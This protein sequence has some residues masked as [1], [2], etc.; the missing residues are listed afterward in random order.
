MI[1][2]HYQLLQYIS[3]LDLYYL[4][5]FC[6]AVIN[7]TISF[8]S[9]YKLEKTPKTQFY[10]VSD[11]LAYRTLVFYQMKKRKL[12]IWHLQFP[13][14]Y[15]RTVYREPLRKKGI[16]FLNEYPEGKEIK[17]NPM[18]C[19]D[20]YLSP[21]KKKGRSTTTYTPFFINHADDAIY[22]NLLVGSFTQKSYLIQYAQLIDIIDFI[23]KTN[24]S[25]YDTVTDHKIEM[26]NSYRK[27][28]IND[29]KRTVVNGL[30]INELDKDIINILES[31]KL[32]K[33]IIYKTDNDGEICSYIL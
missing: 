23:R 13:W 31:V 8:T 2:W 14:P 18:G 9:D 33:K 26:L 5:I 17:S 10:A 11:I 22:P 25:F 12:P 20:Y 15:K 3:N 28:L 1:L 19:N 4:Q 29:D 24:L 16:R 32:K 21:T 6:Q 27:A 30:S 7:G